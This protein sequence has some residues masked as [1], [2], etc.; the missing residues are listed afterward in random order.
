MLQKLREIFQHKIGHV[1]CRACAEDRTPRSDDEEGLCDHHR[2]KK[3]DFVMIGA[4]GKGK[5]GL[6]MLVRKRSSEKLYAMKVVEKASVLNQHQV[7]Y[8]FSERSVLKRLKHPFIVKLD[9]AFQSDSRAFFVMEYLPGG[10]MAHYLDRCIGKRFSESLA[11]FYAAEVLTALQYIHDYGSIYRDLKPENILLDAQGHACLSDFGLAKDFHGGGHSETRAQSFVGS[12]FYVAPEVLRQQRYGKAVDWWAFGVLLFRMLTGRVPFEGHNRREVFERI[13]HG[14]VSFSAFPW[15]SSTAIDLIQRLLVKEERDRL[16][17]SRVKAHR[18]F[19]GVDWTALPRKASPP[20][21]YN[22]CPGSLPITCAA[23]NG[24]SGQDMPPSL[25]FK[26][27]PSKQKLFDGFT[28][29]S[30][31]LESRAQASAT[32]VGTPTPC[33][34]PMG[35]ATLSRTPPA[36][37][38]TPTPTTTTTTTIAATPADLPAPCNAGL[39]PPPPA[40]HG[41][42]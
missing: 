26:L 5:F 20:P 39:T 21:D 27:T 32:T 24:C 12:P 14:P 36:A 31:S 25:P 28:Y 29:V 22:P 37:T 23:G 15:V 40:S 6:V 3:D 18:F 11:R 38:F 41:L 33:G 4:L 30:G 8:L 42:L 17:G 13:L 34:P 19:H 1:Q 35:S 9:Y 16:S 7:R 2:I 10:D